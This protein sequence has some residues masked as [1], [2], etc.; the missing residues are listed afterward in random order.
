MHNHLAVGSSRALKNLLPLLLGNYL[1][2]LDLHLHLELLLISGIQSP[3]L[4]GF[5][6]TLRRVGRVVLGMVA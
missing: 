6:R 5:V 3:I 1:L 4:I 2:L